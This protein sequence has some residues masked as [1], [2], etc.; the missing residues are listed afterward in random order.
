MEYI[1]VE[2]GVND[3]SEGFVLDIGS[4]Y[5]YLSRLKDYRVGSKTTE[6]LVVF[7]TSWWTFWCL[8]YWSNWRV[9]TGCQA[10]RSGCGTDGKGYAELWV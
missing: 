3:V 4:L 2:K 8:S 9:R 6:T 5:D 10:Y 7:V 1:P